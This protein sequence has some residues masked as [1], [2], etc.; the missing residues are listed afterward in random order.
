MDFPRPCGCKGRRSCLECEKEYNFGE[1]SFIAEYKVNTFIKTMTIFRQILYIAFNISLEQ[2]LK[3]YVFCY[4]CNKIYAGDNAAAIIQSH[5][6][7]ENK[8]GINFPGVFVS[9]DF[10]TP[11]EENALMKGIDSFPW[12]ISQSGRRKQVGD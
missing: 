2:N 9:P 8:T 7:H 1:N 6:E 11:D 3:D 4:K 10:I 12:V 5:P